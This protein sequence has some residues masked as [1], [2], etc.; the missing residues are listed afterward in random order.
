MAVVIIAVLISLNAYFSL[1]EI[2]LVAVKQH[3]LKAEEE[4]KNQKAIAAL[5]LIKEPDEFLGAVQVGITLLGIL[6]GV[7]GGD[8]VATQL[9]TVLVRHGLN[10]PLAHVLSLVAGIGAITYLTIIVG[11]LLP[12]S[13]AL[14]TP[15]NVSLAVAPSLLFFTRLAYPFIKLLTVSTRFLL[16]LLR[17]KTGQKEQITEGDI[18]RMLSTARQQGVL[19]EGELWLHQNVF[20][21]ADLTAGRMMKPLAI[22]RSLNNAWSR[23]RVE[24]E[25]ERY[26]YSFFPV[27]NE[28]PENIVGILNVKSFFLHKGDDW[29]TVLLPK[30]P[31]PAELDAETVF[32]RFKEQRI[33]FALVVN[34]ESRPV[35]IVTMQDVMEGVFGD[36]PE[37]EDFRKYFYQLPD[38]SWKASGF[39]HLQRLRRTLD[40]NWLRPFEEKYI[41][42]DE[43]LKG[44]LGHRPDAG[45][46]FSAHGYTFVVE[47]TNGEHIKALRIEK[48]K[49][50]LLQR[51]QTAKPL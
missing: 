40:M 43:F 37:L 19:E 33:H 22:V 4:K 32:N 17:I 23:R 12:K 8:L 35:G 42:L 7:Y 44:E 26:P 30:E 10:E 21:F 36:I 3:Q 38:K 47:E 14:Q 46:R 13:I 45:E 25:I 20:A 1:A 11:E 9:Q 48:E 39:I 16:R 6:E 34:R 24:E 50:D 5:R 2:A 15:L 31:L 18:K 51:Q 27:Y 29:Q 28:A 49:A 41:N